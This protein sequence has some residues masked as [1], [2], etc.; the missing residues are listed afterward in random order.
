[1]SG[2][3]QSD[4][5]QFARLARASTETVHRLVEAAPQPGWKWATLDRRSLEELPDILRGTLTDLAGTISSPAMLEAC[6]GDEARLTRAAGQA[7]Y[8]AGLLGDLAQQS[9]DSRARVGAA[10]VASL[11]KASTETLLG[12]VT[13]TAPDG[14]HPAVGHRLAAEELA[15]VIADTL[16]HIG[17]TLSAPPMLQA[18]PEAQIRLT[19]AA[20]RTGA[21]ARSARNPVLGSRDFPARLFAA[22]R[23]AMES[24]RRPPGR[25]TGIAAEAPH[26]RGL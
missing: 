22:G 18:Y 6:P 2:R 15:G 14:S 26:V 7:T 24:A 17:W 9:R 8:A 16:S 25:G 3:D 4:A 1:M 11:A 19:R 12:L 23:V 10:Q 5:C 21:A 13:A 20:H